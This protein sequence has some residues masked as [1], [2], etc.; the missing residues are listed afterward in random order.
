MK[1][2]EDRSDWEVPKLVQNKQQKPNESTMQHSGTAVTGQVRQE[3]HSNAGK[4]SK[5]LV[6]CLTR[7]GKK[8]AL[9]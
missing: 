7:P 8:T 4:H 1:Q 9:R 2:Q 3:L 5:N 6:F